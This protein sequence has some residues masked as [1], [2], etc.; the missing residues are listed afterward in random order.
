MNKISKICIIC[1]LFFSVSVSSEAKLNLFPQPRYVP[2]LSFYGDSGKAYKLKDFGDDL[3]IAVVWSR[4]CG[5]CLADLKPLNEFAKS[6]VNDGI[7]VILISPE[8][9]WRS[10]D[11][12]RLFLKRFGAPN[13]VSFVDKK[14]AFINGMG[15]MATP[16]ALLIDRNG[17]EVGQISGAAKWDDPRVI[18]YILKLKNKL[19]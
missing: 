8:K 5:P 1:L 9:E 4:T 16:T 3:L 17:L 18:E 13:L 19:R 2:N 11:E 10:A 15:I 7:R 12:K 6:V 14:S